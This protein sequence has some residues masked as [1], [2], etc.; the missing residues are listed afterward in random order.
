MGEFSRI[1]HDL[2]SVSIS[3]HFFFK[4]EI[5][6]TSENSQISNDFSLGIV[7]II[8]LQDLRIYLQFF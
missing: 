2:L 6:S 5:K 3:L 8:F 4:T 1:L 7:N